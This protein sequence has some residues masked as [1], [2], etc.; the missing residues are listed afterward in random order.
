VKHQAPNNLYTFAVM[1]T[2]P[3][4]RWLDGS[5]Y[6]SRITRDY[7]KNQLAATSLHLWRTS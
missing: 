5:A 6:D 3:E 4:E 1:N 7:K 2:V